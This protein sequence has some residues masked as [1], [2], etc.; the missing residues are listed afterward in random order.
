MELVHEHGFT[1]EAAGVV[2]MFAH[3]S[4]VESLAL[5]AGPAQRHPPAAPRPPAAPGLT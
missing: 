1:L 4:H 3:T 5:L 2:D